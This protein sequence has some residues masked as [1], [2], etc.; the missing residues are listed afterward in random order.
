MCSTASSLCLL[1]GHP[2]HL[3]PVTLNCQRGGA[4]IPQMVL[5]HLMETLVH[6]SLDRSPLALLQRRI[7]HSALP[8]HGVR[9]RCGSG[10]KGAE[11]LRALRM[12]GE[13]PLLE[14]TLAYV[15]QI[16]LARCCLL[17]L[18]SLPSRE[19]TISSRETHQTRL[20]IT[21]ALLWVQLRFPTRGVGTRRVVSSRRRWRVQLG[22][23]VRR[24]SRHLLRISLTVEG[25]GGVAKAISV[26][27]RGQLQIGRLVGGVVVE[28]LVAVEWW[29]DWGRGVWL[30]RRRA[31]GLTE[32]A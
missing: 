29:V 2:P 32:Q 16:G 31:V 7:P 15:E 11:V 21:A 25:V 1:I 4:Q 9:A 18:L 17:T 14:V 13:H 6:W 10:H 22:M 23:C 24:A 20:A 8:R 3:D 27:T 30:Y 19:H 28:R 5:Q 12:I 26:G